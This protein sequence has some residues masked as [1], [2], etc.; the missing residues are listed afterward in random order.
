M[1]YWYDT[2]F[3]EDGRVIDLISIGIVA[4]DGREYYAESAEFDATRANLFVQQSVFPHLYHPS[5]RL[6]RKKIAEQVFDFLDFRH[7]VELWGW[8]CA[9]D[10]VALAQLWGPMIKMPQHIPWFTHEIE[11]L[12]NGRPEPDRIAP[13][14]H[15]ALQDAHWHK[16]LYEH[17]VE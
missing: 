13:R 8:Y 10:H 12:R 3:I 16:Q 6:P 9:Y 2:E 1:K 15:N 7:G 14:E 11:Q 5:L 4:E 17:Y